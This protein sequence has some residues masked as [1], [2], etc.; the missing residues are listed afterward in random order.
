AKLLESYIRSELFPDERHDFLADVELAFQM[1]LTIGFD[2]RSP[3]VFAGLLT[4]VR[5][6]IEN[7]LPGAL[8]WG[9]LKEPYKGVSIV[10]IKAMDDRFFGGIRGPDTRRL[11]PSIYYALVDGAFFLSLQEAPLHDIIDRSVALKE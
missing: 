7:T 4:S 11:N 10:R 6:S 1:P 9:L 8:A 5:K 3:V 2:V